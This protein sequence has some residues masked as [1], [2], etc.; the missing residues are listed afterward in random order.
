MHIMVFL[1]SKFTFQLLYREN[2][3]SDIRDH[4]CV[5]HQRQNAF[6]ICMQAVYERFH[7]CA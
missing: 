3:I 6:D 5:T 4:I 7:R 2:R 1:H